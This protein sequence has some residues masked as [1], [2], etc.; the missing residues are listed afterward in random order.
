MNGVYT[1]EN[2][3]DGK[4]RIIFE[5]RIYEDRRVYESELVQLLEVNMQMEIDLGSTEI[6]PTELLR[7]LVELKR[8]A[9]DRGKGFRISAISSHAL[10]TADVIGIKSKLLDEDTI[11]L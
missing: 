2:L 11:I 10:S 4:V 9:R 6:I 8:M 1:E 3:S 5:E 7:L